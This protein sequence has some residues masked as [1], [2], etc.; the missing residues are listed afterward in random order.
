MTGERPRQA[1]WRDP[2]QTESQDAEAEAEFTSSSGGVRALPVNAIRELSGREAIRNR[3]E[4]SQ[5]A[6]ICFESGWIAVTRGYTVATAHQHGRVIGRSLKHRAATKRKTPKGGTKRERV[7]GRTRD[8]GR[9]CENL[10]KRRRCHK[11]H[12]WPVNKGNLRVKRR[13]PWPRANAPSKAA[14]DPELIGR[15]ADQK[16]SRVWTWFAS[17]WRN[18]QPKRAEKPH[19]KSSARAKRETG[20][21]CYE[22]ERTPLAVEN[23]VGKPAAPLTQGA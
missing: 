8:L 22:A 21:P 6:R 7:P 1:G 10:P 11:R 20:R 14:A 2:S 16:H 5:A 13:D 18:H 4:P 23:S 15:D 19:S 17:R 12:R 3:F 9:I